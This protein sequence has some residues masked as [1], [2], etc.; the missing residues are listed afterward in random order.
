M[1]A[2]TSS[3]GQAVVLLIFP[4][5]DHLGLISVNLPQVFKDCLHG[6]VVCRAYPV[7]IL[8]CVSKEIVFVLFSVH[9][10]S[11]VLTAKHATI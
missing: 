3:F 5:E 6:L 11:V 10:I 8:Y 2:I 4:R 9:M 7:Y 1:Q